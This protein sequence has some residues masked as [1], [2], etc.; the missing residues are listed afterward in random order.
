MNSLL[1]DFRFALRVLAK[2]PG[3]TISAVLVLAL[4][5][6]LNTAMF[7]AVYALAFSPRAFPAPAQLVQLHT[8]NKKEPSHFRAFSHAAYR[9]LGG[10]RDLFAGVLAQNLALVGVGEGA[11]T[12]RALAAIVSANFFDVLGVPLARGRGFTAAEESPG[13]DAPVVIVSH[14]Y[15]RNSGFKPG[16]I[17]SALRLNGRPYTVIGIT[18][19][20]FTGTNA[21][22]GPEY[23]FPLGV[24]DSLAHEGREGRRHALASPNV[25]A[26]LLVARLQPGVTPAAAGAALAGVAAGL[27]RLYPV[28]QKDQTFIAGALP[29]FITGAAPEQ[30]DAVRIFAL[31][32]LGLT[33]AVLL[34]VSLNLAGLLLARGHA[35]RK[36]FAIRLALGGTRVRLVRQLLTEGFVLAVAGG[37]L[38]C[39]CAIWI[40]DVAIAAIASRLSIDFFFSAPAPGALVG[41]TLG[42]CTLATLFFALGPALTLLRRDLIPDLQQNAGEDAARRRRWLPRH[43]LVVAQIALS[44]ALVIGAGLFARLAA[45]AE[46]ADSGIDANGTLVA[47]FDASLSGQDRAHSLEILRT[48]GERLAAVPGVGAV[49]LS[50]AA[51]FSI[52]GN[53][54]SVR[55]PG[56]RPAPDAHPATAAAG[57]AFSVAYDEVGA[58]YFATLGLPLLRG[59][60]FSHLETDHAGAPPVVIIDEALAARLWPGE[61]PLGR[62]IEWAPGEKATSAG[63]GPPETAE[64]VGLARTT[65]LELWEKDP[66]GA[67]YVPFA[68]GFSSGGFLFVR[69]ART[70]TAALAALREPVRRELQVAAPD[71]PLFKVRTFSEHKEAWIELWAIHRFT[72]LAMG[73]SA[74]AALIAVIGLYGAKAYG[75]SRRT[76]EIGIRLALGAEPGRVRAL[77]LREGLTLGLWGIGLGLLLGAAL[78]RLLGGM[79]VDIDGFDPI[80]FGVAGLAVFAAAL[81]AS[82]LPARQATRVSPMTA[83]RTE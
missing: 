18:P 19:E 53:N 28:E 73:F 49:S 24:L 64:I 9:E 74:V 48:V 42:F 82:W 39:C 35:R 47:E 30:D 77:I 27:E 43:P 15:W 63:S 66:P 12:R 6:G 62:R 40:T 59:R 5:I 11:E 68:Q 26:L 29:R 37:A 55:R 2:S 76:R 44:L 67:I 23:Y 36:E 33:G 54:R 25:F 13:A 41:A 52:T 38:G 50:A 80:V 58:D 61:D 65:H 78:G 4:G 32:L 3:F 83:L 45:S 31:I 7:S 81:A 57:R 46:A 8:Q 75:V 71:L 69:S 1:F 17:G 21:T 72:V 79:L 22:L 56:T 10:R 16:L 51:P 14:L 34:I 70:G 20:N 60:A